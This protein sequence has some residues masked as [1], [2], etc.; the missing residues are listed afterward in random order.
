[1]FMEEALH[2]LSTLTPLHTAVEMLCNIKCNIDK[3]LERLCYKSSEAQAY[4]KVNNTS[5][6]THDRT[7]CKKNILS[8]QNT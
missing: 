2:F 1:M 3:V 5:V 8:E 7:E 6:K 4:G